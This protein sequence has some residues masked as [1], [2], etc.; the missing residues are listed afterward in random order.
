MIHF[1]FLRL[2]PGLVSHIV[3]PAIRTGIL[4][5]FVGL[6]LAVFRPKH[7]S[8]R[9]AVWTLV[10]YAG[11]AMPFLSW[12]LP[13]V[14]VPL[15]VPYRQK[16]PVV[17][18]TVPANAAASADPIAIITSSPGAIPAASRAA[19]LLDR[20]RVNAS[21]NAL[22]APQT[23]PF[24][25]RKP[26]LPADFWPLLFVGGYFLAVAILLGR[27]AAGQFLS[28]RLRNT[29][30]PL[31]D[32]GLM[33]RYS[34]ALGITPVPLLAESKAIAVP[35]TLGLRNPLILLPWGWRSWDDAKLGAVLAHE[36]SHVKR[37]DAFTVLL[38]AIHE[39]VFCFSPL[40]WWLDR[41]LKDLAE[42]A[43]D[44]AAL[45]AGADAT[46][47]AEV[48]L[49]FFATLATAGR[50]VRW[51]TISIAQGSRA[52]RRL[53]RIL[54]AGPSA[55]FKK[56]RLLLIVGCALPAVCL[57]AAARP[58]ILRAGAVPAAP[59][60]ILQQAVPPATPAAQ[61]AQPAPAANPAS[62]P[63]PPAPAA[64]NPKFRSTVFPKGV[65][66]PPPS[67]TPAPNPPASPPHPATLA[68]FP[69]PP[70]PAPAP[71]APQAVRST[72]SSS[73]SGNN[74]RFFNGNG[75]PDYAV[76]SGN[77]LFTSGSEGERDEVKSLRAKVKGNF[78]W[79]R[80]NGKS[81]V[82]EDPAT[83]KEAAE[84]FK[85]EEELGK[86]QAAL[87]KQQEALGK[88]QAAWGKQMTAVRVQ[89]PSDL[90]TQME[91]VEAA[92][93]QLGANA[94]QQQLARLQGELGRLQGELGRLQS[95]AGG[96]NGIVGERMG[97]LGRR[98]GELGRQQGRLGR[99]QARLARHANRQMRR[100]I[101]DA[102]AHGLAK[103]VSATQ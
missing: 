42:E 6:A 60:R 96:Q 43:S 30:A 7:V 3:V 102:F 12:F 46:D 26:F 67:P 45:R 94:S 72:A 57:I 78:I 17:L 71:Q 51:Q 61:S 59:A 80:R 84:L 65:R 98:Q 9:L 41:K 100:L 37:R 32:S 56:S 5:I 53:D 18:T 47:Y 70:T 91:H 97:E 89:V 52:E 73:S 23:A 20:Q 15:P 81:Y 101:D 85:P 16:T 31:N 69:S 82:I 22:A 10:L 79:F 49:S 24:P 34:Q 90:L 95:A 92:I 29:A 4:A 55:S 35:A 62:P 77:S 44:E 27:F 75:G 38:S 1:T 68:A 19:A 99:E 66:T 64:P 40:A 11:L 36:L 50:R 103:P 25:A 58:S 33:D 54:H 63:M 28:R 21:P 14:R 8:M 93:K 13:A 48:L 87:G 83:V 74:S 39:C 86:E 88:Q 2:A 76:V